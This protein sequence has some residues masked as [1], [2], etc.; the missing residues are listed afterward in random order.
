MNRGGRGRGGQVARRTHTQSNA[1]SSQALLLRRAPLRGVG[2][3]NTPS[4]AALWDSLLPS[5]CEVPAVGTR[6][7]GLRVV[8]HA[9]PGESGV[10]TLSSAVPTLATL[11]LPMVPQAAHTFLCTCLRGLHAVLHT[12]SAHSHQIGPSVHMHEH[13]GRT[14][15]D[16]KGTHSCPHS[17]LHA[18]DH[19]CIAAI[20]MLSTCWGPL[21]G[22]HSRETCSG[23]K[24][25]R[26]WA[27]GPTDR[28]QVL[29]SPSPCSGLCVQQCVCNM[30]CVCTLYA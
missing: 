27:A 25:G 12:S 2:A 21:A 11:L 4:L 8:G 18:Y 19:T 22:P 17:C 7:D 23:F 10:N 1:F 13:Y 24:L 28:G 26:L 29:E 9:L 16:S 6:E 15:T 5:G 30:V 20:F 3:P 14:H